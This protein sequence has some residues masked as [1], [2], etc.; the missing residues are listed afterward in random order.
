MSLPYHIGN[1]W[2]GGTDAGDGLRDDRADGDVLL[3]PVVP[4]VIAAG[5]G[6]DRIFFVPETYK[7]DLFAENADG[8]A[9]SADAVRVR[10]AE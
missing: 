4:V 6:G 3:R 5:D 8:S 1:G 2:F 9:S 10:P 7:R